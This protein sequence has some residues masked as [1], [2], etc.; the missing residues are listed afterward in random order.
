MNKKF[1]LILSVLA[2]MSLLLANCAAPSTPPPAVVE[3][4]APVVTEARL[5]PKP[6]LLLK[7]QLLPKLPRQRLQKRCCA[8]HSRGRTGSTRR[9]ATIMPAPPH[10][11]T[12]TD[13]LVFPNAAGGIDPSLAKSWEISADG[14]VY[15]FKLRQDATFHD[16]APVKASDVVYSYNRMKDIGEGYAYLLTPHVKEMKAVDDF[17]VE[18]SINQAS[19]LFLPSLVRLYVVNEAQVRANTKADGPYADNGDYGKEYLQTND[20]GSGPYKVKE[21]PLEQ[22]L[23]MEKFADWWGEFNPNTP[24]KCVSSAPPKR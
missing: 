13:S 10:W 21:F 2:I 7:P 8:S 16:G 18:I 9:L 17:T 19:A 12:C 24:M 15:T 11:R 1:L 4:E 20:A 6:Q 5:L 14:L 23:L 3:T 22:Y